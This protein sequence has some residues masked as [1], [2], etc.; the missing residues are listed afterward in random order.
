MKNINNRKNIYKP[1][2]LTSNYLGILPLHIYKTEK[3]L[4]KSLP[5]GAEIHHIDYNK[6][7]NE[8]NNLVICEDRLYHKLL[9]VKT[10]ALKEC[11]HANWRKC[12]FCKQYDDIKNL[13]KNADGLSH[14][15]CSSAYS[16]S[17]YYK[18]KERR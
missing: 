16:L 14:K 10:N 3:A 17:L 12:K 18:K 6:Q 11:G 8:N 13:H 9:H 4:G 2:H 1:N 7:N 5:Q 15:K